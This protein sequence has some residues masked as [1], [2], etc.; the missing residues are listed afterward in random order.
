MLQNFEE[1]EDYDDG[2]EEE[3]EEEEENNVP[4]KQH[5]ASHHYHLAHKQ[6]NYVESPAEF[7]VTNTSMKLLAHNKAPASLT[8]SGYGGSNQAISVATFPSEDSMSLQSCEDSVGAQFVAEDPTHHT[9]DASNDVA[10]VGEAR[11]DLSL[12]DTNVENEKSVDKL[13]DKINSIIDGDNG[14]SLNSIMN[15]SNQQSKE[16]LPP[17]KHNGMAVSPNNTHMHM[18]VDSIEHSFHGSCSSFSYLK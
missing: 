16:S 11:G 17:S 2:V 5:H 8:S 15:T 1:E 6:P 3:E 13:C 12:E 4:V 10:H 14:V 18:S 9:H 7:K